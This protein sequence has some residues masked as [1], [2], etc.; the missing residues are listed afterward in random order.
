MCRHAKSFLWN[1]MNIKPHPF[2]SA[3]H[4]KRNQQYKVSH[5]IFLFCYIFLVAPLHCFLK[6]LCFRTLFSNILDITEGYSHYSSHCSVGNTA[7]QKQ[8]CA[9]TFVLQRAG[10]LCSALNWMFTLERATA[11]EPEQFY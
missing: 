10:Q 2:T 9:F 3:L 5:F 6:R 7:R 4:T 8:C 11:F 1:C